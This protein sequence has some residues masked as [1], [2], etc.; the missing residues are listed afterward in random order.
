MKVWHSPNYAKN[1]LSR[2]SLVLM[3]TKNVNNYDERME[4]RIEEEMVED[5]WEI[6]DRHASISESF[7]NRANCFRRMNFVEARNVVAEEIRRGEDYVPEFLNLQG[8]RGGHEVR[9]TKILDLDETKF[10]KSRQF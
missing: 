8:I 6:V 7:R 3:S 1:Y 2:D 9:E 5:I 10:L 4:R